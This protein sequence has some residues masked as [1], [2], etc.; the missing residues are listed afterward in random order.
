MTTTSRFFRSLKVSSQYA[1]GVSDWIAYISANTSRLPSWTRPYNQPIH[2]FFAMEYD[3]CIIIYK[4]I[5]IISLPYRCF[6][7]CGSILCMPG[8]SSHK[9]CFW[10]LCFL[11]HRSTSRHSYTSC[12]LRNRIALRFLMHVSRWRFCSMLRLQ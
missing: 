7:F 11:V 1:F 10:N 4:P 8:L 5:M 12:L 3:M 2:F 9:K 6:F